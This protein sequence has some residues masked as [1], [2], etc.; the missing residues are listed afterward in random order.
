MEK[1]CPKCFQSYDA[2]ATTCPADGATLVGTDERSLI[3]EVLDS[4][5]KILDIVGQGGMGVVYRAEQ[6]IIGRIVALKVLRRDI[7]RDASQV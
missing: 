2:D 1:Y 5:Y 6:E 4:R 3:G 7:V